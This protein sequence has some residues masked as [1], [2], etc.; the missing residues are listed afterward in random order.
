MGFSGNTNRAMIVVLALFL[1]VPQ[2]EASIFGT[3]NNKALLQLQPYMEKTTATYKENSFISASLINLNSNINA[4]YILSLVDINNTET[5]YN[6]L[7]VSDDLSLRL[8]ADTPGL[9]ITEHPNN[10]YECNIDNEIS[11]VFEAR[12]R[13]RLSY[14]PVCN[15]MLFIVIKQDGFQTM[16]EQGAEVF[17]WFAGDAGEQVINQVKEHF[18]QDKYVVE[19]LTEESTKLS[20]ATE[21]QTTDSS[22]LPRADIQE[23]YKNTTIPANRLGLKTETSERKL[24]AGHWYPLKNFPAVYASMIMPG[25]VSKDI[26]EAHKDR[27]N[28]LDGIER[29]AV[30]YLMSFSLEKY[31]LG[32][33]HGTDHPGVGWSPRARNITRDNPYGPDGFNRVAPLIPIGHVP[34]FHWSNTIGTFSGGFQRNHSAFKY[35]EL[36]KTNKA[37]HYG[38]MENGVM[39]STPSEG[40]AT[41]IIYKNGRVELKRWTAQ[42]NYKLPSIKHIRQNG[43]PL[44]HRDENAQGMSIPGKWVKYWGPGNWSG[45]VDKQLR[46]PR[47][48]AC[49]IETPQDRYLVYAYFSGA[50]PS[51]MARVFQSYGCSFALHLDMNSPGQTYA[52][53]FMTQGDEH[54][55]DIELL[56]TEMHAYMGGNRASPRYFIKPDYKDFF[57]I[58]RR[59]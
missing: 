52:S 17:R 58:I 23:R 6:I 31:T 49:I 36:S 37:H 4:W 54:S 48:G 59:E 42:D 29:T 56:M 28:Y 13:T 27:V 25:M 7:P 2:S 11:K 10:I 46:A 16:I 3:I 40:L 44:I 24:L 21:I 26:Q 51:A 34:P 41:I 57:Y 53:L 14:I 20:T 45:T 35:G 15:D 22:V 39:L 33:G 43:V 38:F 50:T 18:F 47:G 12:K 5:T 8:K 32:W 9:L 1:G 30:V 55:I 19:E